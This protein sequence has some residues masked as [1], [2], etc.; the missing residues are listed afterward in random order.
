MEATAPTG[1]PKAWGRQKEA[2]EAGLEQD[3]ADQPPPAAEEPE[4]YRRSRQRDGEHG[5]VILALPYRGGQ[6]EE[7]QRREAD[8]EQQ[9]QS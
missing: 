8:K 1:E 9:G 5:P 3:Q 7:D 4:E 2:D 6:Q